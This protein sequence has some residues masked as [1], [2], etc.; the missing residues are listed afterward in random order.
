M[1]RSRASLGPVLALALGVG[2]CNKTPAADALK[3]SEEAL[4]SAPEIAAYLPEESAV[5]ATVLRDARVSF[6]EGRY[7]DALRAAQPLPDRIAGARAAA[8]RRKQEKAGEWEALARELP[9]RIDAIVARLGVLVAGGWISSE[10]QSMAQAEVVALNQGF[11]DAAA[12]AERGE[13]T[14]AIPV[15]ADLKTRAEKLASALG[16]KGAAALAA[17]APK[18]SPSPSP[19]PTPPTPTPTPTPTQ[20]PPTPTPPPL[21][22]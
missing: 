11:T 20:P 8:A 6:D 1:S 15:A 19:S 16:L 4:A 7:T 18:V 22:P 9:A 17:P 12:A 3:A 13:V 21:S 2:A 5:I 10:R 14:K